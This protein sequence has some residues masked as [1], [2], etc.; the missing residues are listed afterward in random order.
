MAFRLWQALGLVLIAAQVACCAERSSQNQPD[1]VVMRL[2]DGPAPLARGKTPADIPT[3]TLRRPPSES[4]NGTAVVICPG[5]GYGTLVTSYEGEEVAHW[6]TSL[7]VTT[8]VLHYRVAPY[9]H[10]APLIDVQR[11][12]RT[13]RAG[14]EELGI[15]PERVGIIGF[16]AGG[17]LASTAATHF[18]DQPMPPADEI[19]RLS[20][21]P[22]FAIMAYPVIS[23]EQGVTHGGSR[24]NLLGPNPDPALVES[25]ST[26]NAVTKRTPPAFLFHTAADT[27]VPAENSI[28]FFQACLK[29]GVPAEL[30]VFEHGK[31]GVGLAQDEPGLKMWPSLCEAWMKRH[32]W[33]ATK[34][35]GEAGDRGKED[36]G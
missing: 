13:V 26:D 15:D 2:W 11:A 23:M 30:H 22:D 19:D 28:R 18:D 33:L 1:E 31:H 7:G 24:K 10:P 25:M 5:G 20:A 17:H 36:R 3:L 6:L 14:A 8:F 29:A 4:S 35:A 16:S 27:A 12:I 21:R 32:G 34:R 9:Q